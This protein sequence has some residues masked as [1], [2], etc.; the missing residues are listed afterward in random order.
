MVRDN[1]EGWCG[2][3]QDGSNWCVIMRYE[4]EKCAMLLSCFGSGGTKSCSMVM[5]EARLCQSKLH[6]AD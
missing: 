4:A 3:V 2:L 6:D 1:A 5:N